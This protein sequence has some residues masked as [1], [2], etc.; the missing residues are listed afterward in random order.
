MAEVG[1]PI[2]HEALVIA[3][4]GTVLLLLEMRMCFTPSHL[5]TPVCIAPDRR[6][7]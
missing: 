4:A 2:G 6:N 1:A 7:G 3:T 5:R